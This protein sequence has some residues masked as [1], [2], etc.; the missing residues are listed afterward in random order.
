MVIKMVMTILT[1]LVAMMAMTITMAMIMMIYNFYKYDQSKDFDQ[2][3][4]NIES[5]N[6]RSVQ[7]LILMSVLIIIM[8]Q[9]Q[10]R[11]THFCLQALANSDGLLV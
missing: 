2:Y 3:F 4:K 5:K 10:Y 9:S 11:G 6:F 7:V 1:T 8:T